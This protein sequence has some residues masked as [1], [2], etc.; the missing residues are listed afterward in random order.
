MKSKKRVLA[1]TSLIVGA[2][3]VAGDIA[4]QKGNYAKNSILTTFTLQQY[5]IPH[6]TLVSH[7]RSRG[8]LGF[9][10]GPRSWISCDGRS[11]SRLPQII[12]V[13]VLSFLPPSFA[14][15]PSL[16]FPAAAAAAATA[17]AA[18]AR[19][20]NGGRSEDFYNS[21]QE[22]PSVDKGPKSLF[23]FALP[24]SSLLV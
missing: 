19:W 2:C 3:G 20:Q 8:C 1:L 12:H 24:L 5:Y 4:S 15:P 7:S 23:V 14:S 10:F 18:A 13:F 11:R 22:I 21:P 9:L 16:R 17:A 6:H